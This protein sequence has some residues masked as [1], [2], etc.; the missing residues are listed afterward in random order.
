MKRQQWE[1]KNSGRLYACCQS[2]N[3]VIPVVQSVNCH[4]SWCGDGRRSSVAVSKQQTP[5]ICHQQCVQSS[6]CRYFIEE[7]RELRRDSRRTEMFSLFVIVDR[8][9]VSYQFGWPVPVAAR[10]K[11]WVCGRSLAGITGSNPARGTDVCL[12]RMLRVGG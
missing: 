2:I 11:A 6:P 4:V 9:W 10:S 5:S 1:C 7:C 3:D 8:L 12:L